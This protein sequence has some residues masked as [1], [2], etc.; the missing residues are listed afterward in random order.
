MAGDLPEGFFV[1]GW[2]EDFAEAILEVLG[3]EEGDQFIDDVG[4]I[5]EEE[6]RSR[7]VDGGCEELLGGSESSM[8]GGRK[9]RIAV[10]S[11]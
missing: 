5:W 1:D 7:A 11:T 9:G 3:A 4:A 2:G 8:V 6:R 10:F